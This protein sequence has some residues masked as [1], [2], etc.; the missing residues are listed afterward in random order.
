MSSTHSTKQKQVYFKA[1]KELEQLEKA[2]KYLKEENTAQIQVSVLG[3]VSQ[4]HSDRDIESFQDTTIMKSYWKDLSGKS[5]NFGIFYNPESGSVFI[6]GSLATIF[7]HKI[8]RK[9]L[10]TL[11]SGPYGIFRGI[12]V[13]ETKATN[14]LKLL[15]CGHYLLI[16][17][18]NEDKIRSLETFINEATS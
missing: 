11:S 4:F 16:L 9:S 13:T 7:L 5:V 18:G 12:G 14:Y 17:R 10:A 3:K 6:V 1:Y 15:N 8:N 2:L